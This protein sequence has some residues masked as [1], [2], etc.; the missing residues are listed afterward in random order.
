MK[1]SKSSLNCV[2]PEFIDQ[3]LLTYID[4]DYL[5]RVLYPTEEDFPLKNSYLPEAIDK[6]K[7]IKENVK[8]L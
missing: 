3:E 4:S 7:S 1:F 2:P 6:I 5:D 8:K